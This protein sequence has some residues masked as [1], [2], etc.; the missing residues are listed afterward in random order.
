MQPIGYMLY[1]PVK[2]YCYGSLYVQPIHDIFK[3]YSLQKGSDQ[4]SKEMTGRVDYWLRT[5]CPEKHAEISSEILT[6]F[7]KSWKGKY[8][9]T[10][11]AEMK[12]RIRNYVALGLRE[13]AVLKSNTG[14]S[15]LFIYQ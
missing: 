8:V 12:S 3:D 14:E 10:A 11:R 1:S 7:E 6:W 13:I 2:N 15:V 4:F 5:D 9:F